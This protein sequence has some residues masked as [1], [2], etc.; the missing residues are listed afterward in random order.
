M[1]QAGQR[2]SAFTSQENPPGS[3]PAVFRSQRTQEGAAGRTTKRIRRVERRAVSFQVI[4]AGRPFVPVAV[5]ASNRGG[6][7]GSGTEILPSGLPLEDK[8]GA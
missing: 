6:L 4:H 7:R 1:S 3:N 5:I 8:G 2:P